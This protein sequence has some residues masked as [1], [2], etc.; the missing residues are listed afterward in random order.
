MLSLCFKSDW[1]PIHFVHRHIVF[2]IPQP[3]YNE[4]TGVVGSPAPGRCLEMLVT[5]WPPTPF[6]LFLKEESLS[7][8]YTWRLFSQPASFSCVQQ[9]MST[10]CVLGD[11]MKSPPLWN[12]DSSRRERQETKCI[13]SDSEKNNEKKKKNRVR[14]D[15]NCF[16][17]FIGCISAIS[18]PRNASRLP[19]LLSLPPLLR[20][21]WFRS[22]CCLDFSIWVQ[23]PL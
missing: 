11:E 13:M 7:P 20:C 2:V 4:K 1:R 9:N 8:V 5:S 22:H 19:L 21:R 3:T 15:S 16:Y 12:L 17:I 6:R 14:G 10:N 23:F 18:F